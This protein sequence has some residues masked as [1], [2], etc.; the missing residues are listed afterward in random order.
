MNR[1]R[2]LGVE[3]IPSKWAQ[4]SATAGNSENTTKIRA[5]ITQNSAASICTLACRIFRII[6]AIVNIETK[7]R[8][9]LNITVIIG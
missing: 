6:K 2:K 9:T 1:K 8:I 3:Y 4:A 5:M 7:T